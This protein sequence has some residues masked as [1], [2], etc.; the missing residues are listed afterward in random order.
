MYFPKL[1]E[2]PQKRVTVDRFLGLDRRRRASEGALAAMENLTGAHYPALAV[3]S[4]RSAAGTA[5]KPGGLTAKDALI[6]VDGTALYVGGIKTGLVLTEGLKQLVSMGA[7]LVIWP[8]KK[9]INTKDL[10]DFGSLE[11]R[12]EST[13]TVTLRLCRADGTDFGDWQAGGSAPEE[14]REEET[15][16]K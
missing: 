7:Y 5:V 15:V 12:Y 2:P 3:R 4:R 14:S 16:T 13:G 1:S 10:T 8:D 6:W 11:R 9:Y